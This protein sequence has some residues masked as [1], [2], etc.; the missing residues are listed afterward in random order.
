MSHEIRTP[1]NGVIGMT[2]LLLETSL[3]AKQRSMANTV[4]T[5]AEALLEILNDILDFSKMEAGKLELESIDFNLSS[6]LEDSLD[7]M[8]ERASRKQVEL[9]GLVFPDVPTKIKRRSRQDSPDSL[10]FDRERDQIY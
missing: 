6:T 3:T 8:A 10:E 4:S 2:G 7:L 5:S 1:M 9:T